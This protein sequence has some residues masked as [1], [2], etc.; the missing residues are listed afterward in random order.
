MFSTIWG[1]T[2]KNKIK[3][4]LLLF[5]VLCL[6]LLTNLQEQRMVKQINKSV[7]SIYEDRLVV[8]NYIWTLSNHMQDIVQLLQTPSTTSTIQVNERL[9]EIS[10]INKLYDKTYLTE[11]ENNNFLKFKTFC[12]EIHKN[13]KLENQQTALKASLEAE[14]ILKT[15]SSIQVE[16]GKSKLDEILDITNTSS[17]L[18]YIEIVI[19]IIIA[20]L[21]QAIVLSTKPLFPNKKME[22]HNLN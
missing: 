18:S 21:I 16:E 2:A 3:T 12:E 13:I 20:I 14:K 1:F 19:I 9:V 22:N 11:N 4:A 5:S 10:A 8:G 7:T 17:I 6:V 15:L